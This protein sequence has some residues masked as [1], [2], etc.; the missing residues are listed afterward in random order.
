MRFSEV[1]LVNPNF[2]QPPVAPI[3]LDYIAAALRG[4][5]FEPILCDL[6]FAED[7][8][9][10]L[11]D[12]LGSLR[13]EAVLVTVRNIDD[14]YFASQDF[15]LEKTTEVIRHMK[16]RTSTP[17]CLGGVGFSIAPREVLAYTGAHY[18]ITGD[19]ETAV[20]EFLEALRAGEGFEKVRGLVYREQG[21]EIRVNGFAVDDRD[22]G[23]PRPRRF[24]DNARY[25]RE[26]GQAGIETKRGCAQACVYCV[27]PFA[28]GRTQRLRHPDAVAAE[29]R[30]F[31]EQGIDVFHLCDS[32]FN[33]PEAHAR[34]VCTALIGAGLGQKIRW[35]TYAYP[36]PFDVT[37][38][39]A[40]REAGCAG[41]NF[42]VDHLDAGILKRLGRSYRE[43]DVAATA[44]ACRAAG[45]TVMFDMLL[46]SPGE[47]RETL[48]SAIDG[49]RRIGADRVGLSCGVRVYP[50]TALAASIRRA[51]ALHQ[52]PGL[53]GCVEGNEDLLKPV[54][55]VEPGLG[56]DIHD[57][58]ERLVAG[59][60]RF[61]HANPNRREGNYNYNQNT[62]LEE[63]IRAGARGAYW[64]ILRRHAGQGMVSEQT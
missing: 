30:D 5:G 61:L 53:H 63:A 7:W 4:R 59:D 16:A 35:Y 25:F 19:G 43:E 44:R 14:A 40:M 49:M 54:F 50:N 26:G 12:V 60:A 28:K 22:A 42:G 36:V 8:R 13:P 45:I 37:M 57:E 10:A 11:A 17:I 27:E 6:A 3:G 33:L 56:V 34:A 2:M 38:A 29:F 48:V 1:L 51:G 21:G 15:I 39:E 46:G 32:E 24:L 20:A 9:R 64:D 41:I 55:F 52:S 23:V 18:G 47:T 58:V 31:V 62:V